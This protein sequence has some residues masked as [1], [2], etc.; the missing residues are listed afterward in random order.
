[1]ALQKQ[2]QSKRLQSQILGKSCRPYQ[3]SETGGKTMS[4]GIPKMRTVNEIKRIFA[5]NGE[6]GISERELRRLALDGAIPCVYA[7]RRLLINFD[8]LVEY[9]NTHTHTKAAERDGNSTTNQM[10]KIEINPCKL[11]ARQKSKS[12]TFTNFKEGV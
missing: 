10:P 3:R 9:L 6:K 1:M 7:G 4:S 12:Q 2:G 5:E 8:G 11:K